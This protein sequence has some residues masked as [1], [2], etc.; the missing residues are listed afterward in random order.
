MRF[1]ISS[2]VKWFLVLGSFCAAVAS[3]VAQTTG[4]DPANDDTDLF[5]A[6]PNI[7]SERPNVLIILDNTANW[8]NAFDNE[9]SALVS[10]VNGLSDQ[11]NVGL[12]M[13]PETGGG[14][15]A[16]DGGYVK[17]G[18]R[19]MTSANKTALASIVG[20]LDKLADKGNNATTG[21]AMYEAYLY[22]GGRTA[23]AGYGKVKRDYAGN[24]TN[25]PLAA[26]IPGNAFADGSTRVYTPALSNNCQKN[27]IIYIS[28]GPAA[29]NASARS[30]LQTYLTALRGGTTPTQISINPS[31]QQGNWADE[32]A[33]FMANNDVSS[34]ATGN[35]NVITYTVEVDPN[36]TGQGPDMTA[37]LKSMAVNGKGKYFAVTSSSSGTAIVSA[38]NTI[39]S[40]IQSVNSV[41]AAASLPVSANVRGVNLNQVYVGVFRPDA[42]RLPRW[43]GNLKMY[44]FAIDAATNTVFLADANGV[45]A[46]NQATGFIANT[47]TSLWTSGSTFWSY[48][49]PYESTDVGGASDGPDGDLVE[50]GGAAQRLRIKYAA[51]EASS[52]ARNVYTCIPGGSYA[53]CSPL[54]VDGVCGSTAPSLSAS[55]FSTANTDLTP[56]SFNLNTALVSPLTAAV[57]Q[58]LT[59]VSDR[60]TVP[61][62]SNGAGGVTVTLSNGAVSRNISSISNIATRTL[63]GLASGTLTPSISSCA[64]VGGSTK[65]GTVTA[66]SHGFTVGQTVTISGNTKCNGTYTILGT[67]FTTSAFQFSANLG[68]S[69]TVAGGTATGNSATITATTASAHGF[70]NNQQV[71]IGGASDTSYNGTFTIST[72][73]PT[74]TTFTYTVSTPPTTNAPSGT[75]TA[76]GGILTATV[77]TSA[78]HGFSNSANI[79][80]GGATQSQYNGTFVISNASGSTFTIPLSSLPGTETSTSMT[81]SA[82]GSTTVTATGTAH[83]ITT[84]VTIS[85]ASPAGF[86]G[87]Y[88]TAAGTLFNV[89]ANT[90]QFTTS[91]ALGA[92]SGTITAAGAGG[93]TATLTTSI[94]HGLVAGNTFQ[95]ANATGTD[96]TLWNSTW[97]VA[98]VPTATSLTFDTSAVNGGVALAAATG[99]PVLTRSTG[100]GNQ[101]IW[102]RLTSHGYTTGTNVTISGAT[103]NAYN[104]TFS[105]TSISADVFSYDIGTAGLLGTATGTINASIPSTTARATAVN[106]G[107]TTGDLVTITGATPA[108]FNSA[109]AAT[110]GSTVRVTVIDADNFQYTLQT[111]QLTATGTIQ[112]FAS[113]GTGGGLSNLIN[114]IRGQDN[115]ADENANGSSTDVRASIHGDVLHSRPLVV[116]YNRTGDDNDV[117]IFYGTNGGVIHAVRGGAPTTPGTDP[118]GNE[119]WSFVPTEFFPNL[120]RLRNNSP[121]VSSS[122]KRV[123]FGDGSFTAYTKDA[124]GNG[125]LGDTG[126][127]VYLYSTFRRGGRM[128]YSLDAS[129]PTAPKFRWKIDSTTT[130]FGELGQTWSKPVLIPKINAETNPVLLFGGGYDA[131]VEDLDPSTVSTVS[132]TGNVTKTDGTVVNR[133]MGRAIYMVDAITG[134]QIWRA[135]STSSGTASCTAGSATTPAVCSIPNMNYAFPAD[136]TVIRNVSGGNPSR[137]YIGD[138]GGQMWRIDFGNTDKSQWT[139]TRLAA[140]ADQ[141]VPAGRRKFL[142]APDVVGQTG[143]DAILVGTG[144]REHPFD[145]TVA[146][147]MYMFKDKGTDAGPVTGTSVTNPTIVPSAL[148]DATPATSSAAIDAAALSAASGWFVALGSGEKLTGGTISVGGST[149]FGTN[150]PDSAAGGGSCGANLGVARLYQISIENGTATGV[151]VGASSFASRSTTVPGGGFLPPPAYGVPNIPNTNAD[152]TPCTGS[153]CTSTP[154]SVI[155]FGVKCIEPSSVALGSRIRRYWYKDIAE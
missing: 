2:F 119:M 59:T 88:T 108:A 143:Y 53:D 60:I 82:A 114:W 69:A 125:A 38:L 142:Y 45:R 124:D 91:S 46:E 123:Y 47:A 98:T 89:T 137:A 87:T 9:K 116:N 73:G 32:M 3:S 139:V 146:N 50:K 40:E 150:Q 27:F 111:A 78:A 52:P 17:Y 37:L 41:F 84:S 130:Y 20:G 44:K 106:H 1:S 34:S 85:G 103:P 25:N 75:R 122:F 131:V 67:G 83:G 14:N 109:N 68:T 28:N 100:A 7:A 135:E 136:P 148:Y 93:T 95:I 121:K 24:T 80:I 62:L 39:F 144:D 127:L 5:L 66:P 43:N 70:S 120:N 96:A 151:P 112:A 105:V 153:S 56:A 77:T 13:F 113:T 33:Q 64:Y 154:R 152:G 10:V 58:Q 22:F 145:T 133:S 101:R 55:P 118:Y 15:D 99:S 36:G 147:R 63:T 155:C 35:Q 48:R 54:C 129:D 110:S 115:A 57:S 104:G 30:Q 134:R 81:A 117:V 16:I 138:T 97:T 4:F 72:T 12:M 149:F 23:V 126:D 86:N 18:M 51:A 65:I 79:T 19:Q 11:Y 61:S 140:I 6:N 128:M 42:Q 74:A 31:G 76:T 132:A 71:T 29:E 92:A 94:P 90:F 8:N 102:A 107:F 141:S 26:N 49:S 21:L